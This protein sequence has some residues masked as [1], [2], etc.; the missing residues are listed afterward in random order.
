MRKVSKFPFSASVD[1]KVIRYYTAFHYL[2]KGEIP[3]CLALYKPRKVKLHRHEM[4]TAFANNPD[5]AGFAYYDPA[6][7]KV[8]IVK[9]YFEFREFWDAYIE[10]TDNQ[11]YDVI[12]HFRWATHG[13]TN[14]DNCH[15]FA[16]KDGALIHNGIIDLEETSYSKWP[17]SAGRWADDGAVSRS[18]T[19]IFCEDYIQ[20]MGAKELEAARRLIEDK[21]GWS[22][23]V[24]I[25]DDG[26]VMIFNETKGSWK[27]GCWYSNDS[28]KAH[29]GDRGGKSYTTTSGSTNLTHYSSAATGTASTPTP[30]YSKALRNL[31]TDAEALDGEDLDENGLP[32]GYQELDF[33]EEAR[34]QSE[35]DVTSPFFRDHGCCE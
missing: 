6:E 20:N 23:L 30:D 8:I 1:L 15:P 18:D 27:N 35:H 29:K 7:E 12:M 4:A 10:I 13:T 11:K 17:A 24:T 31:I 19:R 3:V 32:I 2:D 33:A 34:M 14:Y 26:T 5:G 28:Y 16:L 22:K 25:H 9:G 21:I